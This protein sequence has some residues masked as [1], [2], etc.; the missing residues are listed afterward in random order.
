MVRRQAIKHSKLYSE[1][2]LNR[3][4]PK[5]SQWTNRVISR[6]LLSCSTHHPIP[7]RTHSPPAP[8]TSF[9][10]TCTPDAAA[11][12]TSPRPSHKRI[13]D[14]DPT[15]RPLRFKMSIMTAYQ[16][17]RL[18]TAPFPRRERICTCRSVS[19]HRLCVCAF[20]RF[21]LSA[22]TDITDLYLQMRSRRGNVAV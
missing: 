18:H 11:Q 7:L 17:V 22:I 8:R 4:V 21:L 20:C 15:A 13:D 6:L 1:T 10:C 12:D 2:S 5:A 9:T 14:H 3:F 16:R 19:F